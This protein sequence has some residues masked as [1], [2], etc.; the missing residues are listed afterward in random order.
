[1]KKVI[2][3][4]ILAVFSFAC[5]LSWVVL[6]LCASM[7][8]PDFGLP[9]FTTLCISLRPL[10]LVLPILMGLYCLWVWF[11][12]AERV[13]S[14]TGFFAATSAAL[15]LTTLPAFVAAYLPML[16]AINHLPKA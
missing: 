11:R 12:R 13:P 7:P 5:W 15:V 4:I 14:W 3:T 10:L 9:G 2:H 6:G 16:D 1:M 8:Q